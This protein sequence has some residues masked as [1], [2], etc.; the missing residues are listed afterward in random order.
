MIE[1]SIMKVK[2]DEGI[3]PG[4]TW[5]KMELSAFRILQND[6]LSNGMWSVV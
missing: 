3:V 5:N 4:K 1:D 2:V 6:C